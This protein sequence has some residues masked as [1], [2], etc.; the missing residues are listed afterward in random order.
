MRVEHRGGEA[1]VRYRLTVGAARHA[2]ERDWDRHRGLQVYLKAHEAWQDGRLEE[3]L[4]RYDEALDLCGRGG[5]VRGTAS[6]YYEKG[7]ILMDLGR[8]QEAKASFEQ[9]SSTWEGVGELHSA[10]NALTWLARAETGLGQVDPALSHVQKALDLARRSDSK[11]QEA[12]SLNQLCLLD[13]ERGRAGETLS[14]CK[15]AVALWTELGQPWRAVDPLSNLGLAYRDLGEVEQAE[16]Y[17]QEALDALEGHPDHASRPP[18]NP[19]S[20]TWLFSPNTGGITRG[21]LDLYLQALDGFEA[22]DRTAHAGVALHNIARMQ[23]RLGKE[24]AALRCYRQSLS[25][26]RARRRVPLADRTLQGS[27]RLYLEQGDREAARKVL[28]E[29]LELSREANAQAAGGGLPETA[30]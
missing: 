29:A 30:R 3:A 9:A 6:I 21:A 22:A 27:G 20:T 15:S 26:L 1:A 7:Q 25:V 5:Y 8:R 2:T 19:A 4:S 16:R 24:N 28:D 23:E 11:G 17:F 14:V 12:N 18:R 10:A 13:L